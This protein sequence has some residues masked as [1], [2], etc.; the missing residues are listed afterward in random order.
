V[1]ERER[2]RYSYAQIG[3]QKVLTVETISGIRNFI[4]EVEAGLTKSVTS[5]KDEVTELKSFS[6]DLGT[7]MIE[8]HEKIAKLN[9]TLDS[10]EKE[11]SQKLNEI[12]ER[13]EKNA[14]T[15]KELNSAIDEVK[16]SHKEEHG[17]IL[18]EIGRLRSEIHDFRLVLDDLMNSVP[19]PK[20]AKRR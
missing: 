13:L 8:T 9:M 20:R 15:C 7:D 11:I 1:T 19:L 10:L 12:I 17:N 2:L 3:E 16:S 5:L 14:T 4:S 18:S 6:E